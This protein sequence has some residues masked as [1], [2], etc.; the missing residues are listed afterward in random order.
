MPR[1]PSGKP[2]GRPRRGSEVAT[3]QVTVRLEPTVDLQA[4]TAAEVDGMTFAQ[5]CA[6]VIADAVKGRSWAGP[7]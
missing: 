7:Q 6:S 3:R 2:L 1:P 4:R 5:W